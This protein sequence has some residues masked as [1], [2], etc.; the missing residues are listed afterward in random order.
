MVGKGSWDA[1]MVDPA[2][3]CAVQHVSVGGQGQRLSAKRHRPRAENRLPCSALAAQDGTHV[4]Q[5]LV[6]IEQ[7]GHIDVCAQITSLILPE[8]CHRVVSCGTG[9]RAGWSTHGFHATFGTTLNVAAE[10]P[11]SYT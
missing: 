10:A 9:A 2:A 5:Q 8:A 4:G 1:R 6:K 3:D 7:S 11:P